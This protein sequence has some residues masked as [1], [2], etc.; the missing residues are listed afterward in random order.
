MIER[1]P[2]RQSVAWFVDLMNRGLMFDPPYQRRSV[3]SKQY[4]RFFIDTIMRNFPSPPIF[5]HMQVSPDGTVKYYVVDGKQRIESIMDFAN[6]K[7]ALPDEFGNKDLD[8]KYFS[9]LTDPDKSRFWSYAVP[10]EMLNQVGEEVINDA[11]DRLNRNVARLTAQELRH[12]KYSGRFISLITE[13]ADDTFWAE[14]YISRTATIRR[15]RD[16]EFVSELFLLTMFGTQSTNKDMLDD[17]YAGYEDEIPNEAKHRKNFGRVRELISK[18]NLNIASNRLSNYSDFYTLWSVLLEFTEKDL[19]L[20]KTREKII[21]FIQDVDNKSDKQDVSDYSKAIVA[22][23][24]SKENRDTRKRI[25]MKLI[26]K[27]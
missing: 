10:V 19:N 8:G 26:V 12:A 17:Y 3:W 13:T 20:V 1:S 6:D 5:L 2:T 18:L 9:E 11:F 16:I 24:N 23:P 25:F 4:K 14:N 7:I 22:Q 21:K 15:M 27:K